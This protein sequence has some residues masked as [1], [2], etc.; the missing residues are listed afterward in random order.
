M[1]RLTRRPLSSFSLHPS[2]LLSLH[3]VER[4]AAEAGAVLF[5]LHL[6]HAAGHLDFCTVVQVTGFGAL[7]PDHFSVLF[8]HRNTPVGAG[9][10]PARLSNP[11]AAAGLADQGG[12]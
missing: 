12:L 9:S 4:V 5:Q 8:G 3:L 7:K 1:K 11:G 2:S 6:L 10:Q